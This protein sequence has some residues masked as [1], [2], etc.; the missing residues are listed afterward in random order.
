MKIRKFYKGQNDGV[1][2]SIFCKKTNRDVLKELIEYC[3][4]RKVTIKE[5]IIPELSK[6]NVLVKGKILDVVVDTEEGEINIELNNYRGMSLH[7]RNAAYIFKMYANSVNVGDSYNDMKKHIQINLTDGTDEPNMP[8]KAKYTLYD[9][10]NDLEY[11]DNL[12]IYELNLAKYKELWYNEGEANILAVLMCDE[13]ELCK[14]EGNALVEKL[15]G[16][17]IKMNQDKKFIEFL[18]AEEEERLLLNTIKEDAIREGIEQGIEKGIEQNKVV[19]AKNMLKKNADLNFISEITELSIEKLEL[20][21]KE[22]D[23]D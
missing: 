7:R 2:K 20:L 4:G 5:L 9:K 10:E 17:I 11:L 12:E 16:E 19:I 22:I 23:K 13:E 8:I 1:F 18:S 3:I 21:R 15:K 6:D 14:I